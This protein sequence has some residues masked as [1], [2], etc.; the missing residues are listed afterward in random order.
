MVGVNI[1][2]DS[3]PTERFICDSDQCGYLGSEEK[4]GAEKVGSSVFDVI[5]CG[6]CA[7][8]V[9][10]GLMSVLL[11]IIHP[12]LGV[13]GFIFGA[14]LALLAIIGKATQTKCP[15][16]KRGTLIDIK[17]DRGQALWRRHQTKFGSDE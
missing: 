13:I 9:I 8:L 7:V 12:A 14:G 5:T 10:G 4:S 2:G 16:C 11:G 1:K 3:L 6:P 17:S 15:A